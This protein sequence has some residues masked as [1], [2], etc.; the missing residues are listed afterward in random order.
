MFR[1]LG[2][3][4]FTLFSLLASPAMAKGWIF[5]GGLGLTIS[6]E[7][8]MITPQLEYVHDAR[9]TYGPLVQ[10]AVGSGSSLFTTSG[11]VRYLLGNHAKFKPAVE[12][13]L[14]L[15]VASGVATDSVGVHIMM[16]MGFDYKIDNQ[17][18]LGTMIRANFAPPLKTFF[19]SWPLFIGRF[20]I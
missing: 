15:A 11:S 9:L 1:R 7:L 4:A 13:A 18:S 2:F 16:G 20:T 6:P 19:I 14:G 5:S 3:F 10:V 8:F 12:G 17:I